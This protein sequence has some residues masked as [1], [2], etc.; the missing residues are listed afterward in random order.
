[1]KVMFI[2]EL[3]ALFLHIRVVTIIQQRSRIKYG[4][5]TTCSLLSL[6]YSL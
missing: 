5:F 4:I 6:P 2:G 1:V 3:T